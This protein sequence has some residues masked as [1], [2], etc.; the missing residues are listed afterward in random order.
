MD[1]LRYFIHTNGFLDLQW[2]Q[3]LLIP[4]RNLIPPTVKIPKDWDL[5]KSRRF[6]D[7]K[8]ENM[9]VIQ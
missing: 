3:M 4:R 1:S 8:F 6:F 2:L 9:G 5:M 7:T